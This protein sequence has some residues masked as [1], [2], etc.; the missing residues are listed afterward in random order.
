MKKNNKNR[1]ADKDSKIDKTSHD[2]RD[3]IDLDELEVV[4]A[5]NLVVGGYFHA[6][7]FSS[8]Y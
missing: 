1:L 2:K 3:A 5:E 4:E 8:W 7:R 6:F